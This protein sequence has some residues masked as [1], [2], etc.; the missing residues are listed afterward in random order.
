MMPPP[1]RKIFFE[2]ALS[3]MAECVWRPA[4][5]VRRAPY[6]WLVKAEL[7]GVAPEQVQV[8]VRG[9]SLLLSG[10][11]KDTLL[12]EGDSYYAME[13]AYCRFERRIELPAHLDD[14]EVRVSSR[15]GLLIVR[16]L[17]PAASGSDK[18]I[19]RDPATGSDSR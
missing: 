8:T 15:D 2:P 14:A 1:R 13:I 10:V 19:S 12:E 18:A 16:I 4:V 17:L 6:G 9:N 11:R 5:D 3:M 7:P